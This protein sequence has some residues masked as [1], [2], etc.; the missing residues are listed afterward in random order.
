MIEPSKAIVEQYQG[1]TVHTKDGDSINGRLVRDSAEQVVIETDPLS[2]TRESIPRDQV[3]SMGP[4]ALS[5]MPEGLL[6]V[7]TRGEILD[8]LAYVQAGGR[9]EAPAFQ[10]PGRY[11]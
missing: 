1:T 10:S 11:N 2:G 3:E 6:N 4:S 9:R 5:P 8:L 7:F